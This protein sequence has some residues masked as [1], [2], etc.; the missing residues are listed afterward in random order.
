MPRKSRIVFANYPHH[1]VQR[2]HRQQAVFFSD[3][4]RADY[5]QTLVECRESMGIRIYAYCLMDNHVHLIIDPGTDASSISATMKR[6]AGRHARR[7]NRRNC[8]RGSLWESRFKCSPIDTDRYLLICGRYVD[9]N[10]VRAR[11]VTSPELFAWSS[12]RARIGLTICDWLDQDPALAA[13]AHTAERR[14]ALYREFVGLPIDEQELALIR[15][16]SSRN[17]LTGSD[18]FVVSIQHQEGVHI[19]RRGRGRPRKR[20]LG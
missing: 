12:Y 7:M 1:V 18:E 14:A 9:L 16:A 13:L 2:G 3:F 10:P 6:L 8:W 19:P 4:D 15:G 11:I 17:Q 5:L 20:A